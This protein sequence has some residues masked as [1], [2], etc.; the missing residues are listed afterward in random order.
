M[1]YSEAMNAALLAGLASSAPILAYGQ[2]IGAGSHLSG[3]TLGINDLTGCEV[4]NTPNCENAQVGFGFGMFLEGAKCV[5][6]V[7]QQDFLL[8]TLDHL[9]NTANLALQEDCKGSFT[10]AF[11]TVDSGYEGPQSRLNTFAELCAL[12]GQPGYTVSSRQ[13]ADYLLDTQI[14]SPGFRMLGFSQRLFR[15]TVIDTVSAEL[16]DQ[17]TG[18]TRYQEGK[19]LAIVASNFSLPLAISLAEKL[20]VERNLECDVVSVPRVDEPVS[21]ALLKLGM[22]A[23]KVAILDDSHSRHGAGR[24]IANAF[25][26]THVDVALFH[27]AAEIRDVTPNAD[28]FTVESDALVAKLDL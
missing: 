24:T 2:N 11:V 23:G 21:Q 22:N 20:R 16:L 3:L 12:S 7:K 27:R 8:L 13:E 10:I 5:F 26:E 25:T 1:S 18:T 14:G 19:D 9:V 15:E 4:L 28:I 6:I 17:E